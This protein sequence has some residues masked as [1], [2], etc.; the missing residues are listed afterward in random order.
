MLVKTILWVE[1]EGEPALEVELR[2]RAN[3]RPLCSDC[4]RARPGYDRL[5]ARRFEVAAGASLFDAGLP[6]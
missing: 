6:D 1:H 4:G 3:S 2:A 5:P